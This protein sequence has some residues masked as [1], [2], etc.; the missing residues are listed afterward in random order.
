MM[1]RCKRIGMK[2]KVKFNVRFIINGVAEPPGHS[3]GKCTLGK[4]FHFLFRSP[5]AQ[6]FILFSK[7][8]TDSTEARREI[9]QR[10]FRRRSK[11]C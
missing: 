5:F 9:S 7:L 2:L 1:S 11:M 8:E 6:I 10:R 4:H 3:E